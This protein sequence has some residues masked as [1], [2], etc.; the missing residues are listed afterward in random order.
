MTIHLS[1][2]KKVDQR[3]VYLHRTTA[4]NNNMLARRALHTALRSTWQSSFLQS[5]V[6]ARLLPAA[7]TVGAVRGYSKVELFGN[8]GGDPYIAQDKNGQVSNNMLLKHVF[9][10]SHAPD[11]FWFPIE[12]REEPIKSVLSVCQS[13]S[14]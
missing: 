5:H 9:L 14:P 1:L 2:D 3:V 4:P 11:D 7:S 10:L 8:V 6:S 12:N 13:V